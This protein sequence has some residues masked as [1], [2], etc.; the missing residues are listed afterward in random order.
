[1]NAILVSIGTKIKFYDLE[2]FIEFE[3]CEI[4]IPLLKNQAG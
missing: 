3:A 2:A 4:T 1:M